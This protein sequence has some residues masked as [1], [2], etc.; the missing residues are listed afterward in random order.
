MSTPH[1]V[2]LVL[3]KALRAERQRAALTQ[4]VAAVRAGLAVVTVQRAELCGSVSPRTLGALAR[5]YGVSVDDLRGRR[6]D[7]IAADGIVR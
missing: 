7:Q 3:A 6:R 2:D 5:V 4:A 1:P